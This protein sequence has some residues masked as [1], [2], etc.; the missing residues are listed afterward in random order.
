LTP[1]ASRLLSLSNN[2]MGASRGLDE[3]LILLNGSSAIAD[4]GGDIEHVLGESQVL[5]VDLEGEFES[6][7]AKT[8]FSVG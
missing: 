2:D 8:Q 1:F 6:T 7:M 5:I 4:D 3:L